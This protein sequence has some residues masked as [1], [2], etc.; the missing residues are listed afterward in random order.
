L[1]AFGSVAKSNIVQI[2][3]KKQLTK[4]LSKRFMA[5]LNQWEANTDITDQVTKPLSEEATFA[6]D[7]LFGNHPG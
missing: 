2:V 7:K 1:D 5:A 6:V 4:Y 3:I